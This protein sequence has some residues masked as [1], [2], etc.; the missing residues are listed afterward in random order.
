S[1]PSL[2]DIVK[3][4]ATVAPLL[5][6]AKSGGAIH[7]QGGGEANPYG[8]PMWNEPSYMVPTKE[9]ADS[10]FR[11]DVMPFNLQSYGVGTGEKYEPENNATRAEAGITPL[12][13]ERN[14]VGNYEVDTKGRPIIGIQ[15]NVPPTMNNPYI[16]KMFERA[17]A[18]VTGDD[19]TRSPWY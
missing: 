12:P 10:G 19:F 6:A 8:D 18:I 9:G 4:G 16:P 11:S 15:G 13:S 5:L 1:G 3:I 2:G 14:D 7:K 17:P